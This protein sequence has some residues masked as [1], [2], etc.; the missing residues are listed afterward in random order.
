MN[1]SVRRHDLLFAS[2]NAR[3]V[4]NNDGK[5]DQLPIAIADCDVAEISIS[6]SIAAA[7]ARS[8]WLGCSASRE[9]QT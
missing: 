8:C 2:A 4:A 7:F 5:L 9:T 1:A 3:E 6:P